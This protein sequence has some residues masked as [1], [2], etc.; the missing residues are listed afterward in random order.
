M[1]FANLVGVVN[2]L[3]AALLV[4]SSVGIWRNTANRALRCYAVMLF[5]FGVYAGLVYAYMLAGDNGMIPG[6]NNGDVGRLLVR[7][8]I[9]PLIGALAAASVWVNRV[10]KNVNH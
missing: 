10:L 6:F 4:F 9:A 2:I 5:I 1:M 7:P 8:L 3:M